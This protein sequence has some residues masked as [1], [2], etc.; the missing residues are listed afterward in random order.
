MCFSL[1]PSP[2]V[3]SVGTAAFIGFTPSISCLYAWVSYLLSLHFSGPILSA[4]PHVKDTLVPWA[5]L[6]PLLFC[7]RMSI[8]FLLP[9]AQNWTQHLVRGLTSRA[10]VSLPQ[11]AGRASPNAA[12][13]AVGHL[14]LERVN[15]W[16]VINL[17]TETICF[18]ISEKQISTNSPG[19]IF[20]LTIIQLFS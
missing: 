16:L 2:L 9:E 17:S 8:S 1:C 15:C 13:D 19:F 7:S 4:S 3:L 18:S 14:C 20:C 10:G 6:W 11:P 12:Q 5:P